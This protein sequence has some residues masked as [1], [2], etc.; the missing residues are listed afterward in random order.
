MDL[1]AFQSGDPRWMTYQQAQGKD[2]QVR[3]GEYSTAIFF[4][5]P[6][7]VEDDEQDH[8]REIIR[9]LKHHAVFHTS[10]IDGVPTRHP[11]SRK[12]DERAPK[13]PKPS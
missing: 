6:F 5:K 11:R 4:T 13:L 9:V 10:Q 12:H 8:G 1:R 2:S 7:E 3:K